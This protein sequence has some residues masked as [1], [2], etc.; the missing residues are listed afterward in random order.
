MASGTGTGAGAAPGSVASAS[1]SD[2]GSPRGSVSGSV[3]GGDDDAVDRAKATFDYEAEDESNITIA[4]GDVLVVTDKSDSDWWEGYVE[5]N[6]ETVGYFPSSFVEPMASGT[7]T[8][9]AAASTAASVAGASA[10]AGEATD[11]SDTVGGSV[12]DAG[13]AASSSASDATGA[14]GAGGVAGGSADAGQK[15]PANG[16]SAA[17]PS[18]PVVAKVLFDYEAADGDDLSLQAGTEVILQ[19]TSDAD[20]WSGSPRSRPDEHG[21]FPASFVEKVGVGGGGVRERRRVRRRTWARLGAA[22][23]GP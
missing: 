22:C 18:A 15:E 1:S 16:A 14:A 19:D 2:L 20:W 5:G 3:S 8:G 23:Q 17:G 9:T 11:G 7:G 10:A 4:V 21:F 12:G 6:P 13:A